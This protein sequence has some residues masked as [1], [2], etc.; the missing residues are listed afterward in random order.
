MEKVDPAAETRER[1]WSSVAGVAILLSA[2]VLLA[3]YLDRS[4]RSPAINLALL[5]G[6]SAILLGAGLLLEKL[7]HGRP[8]RVLMAGGLASLYFTA[9]AGYYFPHLRLI[10]HPA[11]GC[12][13]VV[14]VAVLI[15]LVAETRSANRDILGCYS[16]GYTTALQ[17]ALWFTL[18]SEQ[19]WSDSLLVAGP[20]W[21][22]P[23]RI[24]LP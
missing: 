17:P 1:R 18:F 19:S 2:L 13:I 21:P 24:P 20:P 6:A 15:I 16:I 11:A 14:A 9:F 8:A 22:G 4:A 10:D 7:T 23:A 3:E 12:V 5:F